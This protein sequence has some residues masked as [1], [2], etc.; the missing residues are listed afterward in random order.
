MLSKHNGRLMVPG[1]SQSS[2]LIFAALGAPLR[3]V[4]KLRAGR[5]C[6]GPRG[7]GLHLKGAA[8]RRCDPDKGCSYIARTPPKPASAIAIDEQSR[9]N[10]NHD[11]NRQRLKCSRG[12]RASPAIY[13]PGIFRCILLVRLNTTRFAKRAYEVP[14]AED[15]GGQEPR[16]SRS[17]Q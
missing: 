12:H 15:S 9:D 17:R 16:D 7:Q 14:F 10:S 5:E 4:W 3:G 2:Q 8:D 13:L 6:T 11:N 1:H